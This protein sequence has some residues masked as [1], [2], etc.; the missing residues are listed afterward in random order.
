MKGPPIPV[1]SSALARFGE[2]VTWRG[3]VAAVALF[4]ATVASSE[5]AKPVP[6]AEAVPAGVAVAAA[7]VDSYG[8]YTAVTPARVFDTRDGT[9]QSG[10]VAMLPGGEVRDVQIAGRGG[11][12]AINVAA[13]VMNVTVTNPTAGG[14]LRVWPSG[15]AQPT[16]SNLNFV[17]GQ[18]VPN[19][20]TVAVGA[21][22][23]VSVASLTGLVDVI[24]DVFGSYATE[25]GTPGG[26]FHGTTPA[27]LLDTRDPPAQPLGQGG[28]VTLKVTGVG[29]V[30]AMGVTGV[31]L[32]VTV[33]EPTA[34]GFLTVWPADVALP[35]ASNLN[36]VSGLTVPN[37]TVV[38][39]PTNGLINLFN[40]AGST[41]VIVDVVGWYDQDRSTEAGRFIPFEPYRVWDTREFADGVIGPREYLW[42]VA[43]DDDWGLW[44]S[45]LGS[46]VL[47]VTVTEPTAPGFLTV[48]PADSPVPLA[49]N[50]NFVPGQ[51]VPNL[52]MV[53]MSPAAE[54]R[55]YNS[56]GNTHIVIDVSGAFTNEFA[57]PAA[58]PV[59]V[60][61]QGSHTCALLDN[62]QVSC[63]G[64]NDS[65]QLGNGTTTP[66]QRP[67]GVLG[68]AGAI[69]VQGGTAHSCALVT[70]GT[71]QCWGVNWHGQLGDG[72]TVSRNTPVAVSGLSD[73]TQIA[74]GGEHS[75]ALIVGGQVKCWGNNDQ[76]QI[77][78]GTFPGRLTPVLVSGLTNVTQIAAGLGHTCA[79]LGSGEVKCWGDNYFGQ[80]GD[81]NHGIDQRT[82]VSVVGISTAIQVTAGDGHSC[83]LVAGGQVR[84]WGVVREGGLFSTN[85]VAISGLGIASQ[86]SGGGSHTCAV[87]SGGQVQCWG[88][89]YNGQLGDGRAGNLSA[90]LT[91]VTV[92]GLTSVVQVDAGTQHTCAITTDRR[93]VC[94]GWNSSGQLG[95]GTTTDR[96]TPVTSLI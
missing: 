11:I 77:G 27:R 94:W 18:T 16:V 32:N 31:A 73:V 26:R 89:N 85:P 30:P 14:W 48:Y 1:V 40:S 4:G 53:R 95:D 39:V 2:G 7:E 25:T 33:T 45:W 10:V 41:H 29:G 5:V 90:W 87:V 54:I 49:S 9:G 76:G 34:A 20:V 42:L 50:L 75:C 80:L 88:A 67:V 22:G 57:L 65:G 36:F 55:L 56:A 52:V 17:A 68:L 93:V 79:V 60:A 35:L 8:E 96:W 44:T 72:T 58:N 71:V 37:L 23:K 64:S 83:A 38:R 21:N 47:N 13:V 61:A 86:I 81:G 28:V 70:G 6:A 66:S 91:P 51:T 84:C 69:Q 15:V 59:Q 82:P 19:L 46:V 12:P 74:I 92:S 3:I 24:F 63:W 62:G 78:D 43:E